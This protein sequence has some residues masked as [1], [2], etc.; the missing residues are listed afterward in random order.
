MILL[1]LRELIFLVIEEKVMRMISWTSWMILLVFISL[2]GAFMM[3]KTKIMPRK[4]SI[5]LPTRFFASKHDIMPSSLPHLDQLGASSSYGYRKE[6]SAAQPPSIRLS[7]SLSTTLPFTLLLSL[8]P[9]SMAMA[10]DDLTAVMIAK[11]SIDFL[12]NSLSFLFLC[13]I[14]VSWYPRTDLRQFPYN[15]IVWPTEALAEPLRKLVPPAFGVDIA[16]LVWIGFLSFV[17]EILTG[18]QGILTLL[19]KTAN[20]M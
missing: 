8:L 18:Q 20:E 14:V 13:R 9:V 17:R 4:A 15:V 3:P 1:R 2:S 6:S 7:P 11:P 19:E 5:T 12:V 16:P 10:A